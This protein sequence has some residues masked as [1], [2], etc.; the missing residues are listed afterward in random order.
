M[1]AKVI[2][3][4]EMRVGTYLMLD[5]VAHQVKKM[6]T[7]KT[8]KHGH[9][10]VRFEAVSAMTGKKKV[11]VVPGHDKF[12]VPMIDKKQ[13]Q[14]LSIAGE[15][16]SLMDSESFENFDLSIPEDLQGVVNESGTIEYWDIEGEK[17]MK[18]VM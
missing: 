9:A 13:A 6:D 11:Q 7:S 2:E 10:K 4:T 12:E 14:V 1:V 16:A 8:G 15:T 17:L 3:A 18:K 5:G